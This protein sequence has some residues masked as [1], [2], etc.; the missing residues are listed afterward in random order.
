M[1]NPNYFSVDF[2]SIEAEVGLLLFFIN[3]L[4]TRLKLFYPIN[5]TPVGGGTANNI[6]FKSRSQTNF[7]FPFTLS[8]NATGAQADA[9]ISDLANKCGV[10]GG[11]KSN[12]EINYKITVSI[13]ILVSETWDSQL[14]LT[15]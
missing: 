15:I 7:T 14:L 9:I 11:K 6:D 5:N 10:T 8:Y 2:E 12:L 4:L 3:I 13:N 1:A